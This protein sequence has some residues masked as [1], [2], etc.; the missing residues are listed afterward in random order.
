MIPKVIHYCWF[1]RGPMPKMGKKCIESWRK[2]FPDYEIKE[3]NEDNFDVNMIP[4]MAEAY[5]AKK[6]AFVSDYA[7]FWILYHYGGVYFDIDVEVI[8]PMDEM[9]A[10]G[11]FMA[12]E[13]EPSPGKPLFVAPGLG[14][15]CE[16]G[17]PFY[18]RCLDLYEGEHF[19]YKPDGGTKTVV[20]YIT[21]L[22]EAEGLQQVNEIQSVAG[23]MI[24]P[25]EYMCPIKIEG[26]AMNK[27]E[28]TVSIHYY[29]GTW[30]SP[31]RQFIRKLGRALGPQLTGIL[32]S[33]KRLI[34]Q[35]FKRK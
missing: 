28:K 11:P 31:K 3:W 13:N 10:A 34:R 21:E 7:R 30:A 18:K 24:Y 12:C 22:L 32:I 23:I 2:F 35:V 8:K 27:T 5:E 20:E 4:Y 14:L 16:K 17:H 9:I 6:Y 25:K 15:A 29:A 26:L 19:N 33:A 1:G